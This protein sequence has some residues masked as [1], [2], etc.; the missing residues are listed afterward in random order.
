MCASTMI[1]HEWMTFASP[2]TSNDA[3]SSLAPQT[4]PDQAGK[5]GRQ[6]YIF[7]T[8]CSS[9]AADEQ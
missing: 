3:A 9:N 7:M 6:H 8:R 2:L 1:A 4:Q 5:I